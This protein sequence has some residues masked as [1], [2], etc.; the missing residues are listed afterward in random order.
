MPGP[1]AAPGPAA[2]LSARPCP[3][4]PPPLRDLDGVP[5]YVDRNATRHDPAL[6]AADNAA[7]RPLN[8][9]LDA[10]QRPTERWVALR[11]PAQAE[12]AIGLI[13]AWA[14]QRALLGSFNRQGGY[15]RKWTLAG[16]ALAWLALRDAPAATPE[17]QARIGAWMAEVAQEVRRHY[18]RPAPR[19]TGLSEL[20]NNHMAWAGLAVGAAGVAAQDRALLRWG[21][22][23]GRTFLAGVTAEGAHPQELARGR[24]ALHYHFFALQPSAAL[25]RLGA[26]AGEP[27]GAEELAALDRLAR[28]SFAQAADPSRIAALAG[29]EQGMLDTPPRPWLSGGGGAGLEVWRGD[30][31]I[32]AALA[33]HRPFRARWLGGGVTLLWGGAPLASRP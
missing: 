22:Q 17:R 13:E 28:F 2:P 24:M 6:L 18:D 26:A 32:L 33:A 27:F 14:A 11:D 12:C 16:A 23:A 3:A 29:A 30:P 15:R 25:A 31:V 10:I 4:P 7:A 20:R 19:G 1:F 9:W 21:M 5:F 8:D